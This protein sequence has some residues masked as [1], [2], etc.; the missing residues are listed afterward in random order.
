MQ[1]KGDRPDHGGNDPLVHGSD[2]FITPRPMLG[3][4]KLAYRFTRHTIRSLARGWPDYAFNGIRAGVRLSYMTVA[5]VILPRDRVKCNIC[6]WRGRRFYPNTGPGYDELDSFC[7]GCLCLG[8]QRSLV[9][10]LRHRLDFFN[11]KSRVIEVAPMRDFQAFCLRHKNLDYVSFDIER[12]AMER[13]DITKMRFADDSTDFF[14][15]FHVLEHIQDETGALSEIMRVLRPGG[16]LVMQVP[17]DRSVDKTF[18]YDQPDPREVGHVRRYGR[19]LK[20]RLE[21]CGFEVEPMSVVDAVSEG[22]RRRYGLC[23]EPIY[24]ARKPKA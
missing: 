24:L 20:E 18:E 19:D 13:G 4:L 1:L 14:L 6:G 11:S 23:P 15:C 3:R 22:T 10:L 21:S 8:R 9:V 5:D 17:V 7:A 12:F 2:Q 16:M